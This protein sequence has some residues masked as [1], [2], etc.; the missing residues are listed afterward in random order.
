MEFFF[1]QPMFK[2]IIF[3][4]TSRLRLQPYSICI[5]LLGQLYIYSCLNSITIYIC[6][7][8]SIYTVNLLLPVRGME[9]PGTKLITRMPIFDRTSSLI[10]STSEAVLGQRAEA[11]LQHEAVSISHRATRR[12]VHTRVRDIIQTAR[13][14]R[15]Q[16]VRH[17]QLHGGKGWRRMKARSVALV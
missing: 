7:L 4:G 1:L 10:Y 12:L 16:S 14:G 11:V 13:R 9:S 5:I 8:Y 2:H 15:W 17:I 6:I 3:M